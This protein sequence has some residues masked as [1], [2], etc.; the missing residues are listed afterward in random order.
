MRDGR[1][2][3]VVTG[4]TSGVG[5]AV[6]E[7]FARDGAAI[8]LLARGEDGL[9][10]TEREVARLGGIGL[11]V[12]A[13]V[14]EPPQVD[15]AASLVERNFGPIDIWIN[16]AM[17]SVFAEVKDVDAD[18]FKRVTEVTYLGLVNGTLSALQRMLP[19]DHGVIVQVGSALAYRSIPLQAAYCAAKHAGQGFTQSLRVE[20]MHD[21]SNVRTTIVHLPAL[22]TPQFDHCEAR[23]PKKPQPVPPIYQPEVAA[24]TIHWAAHHRR[25]EVWVGGTT[26]ATILAN[27]VVPGLLDRYLA[28]TGFQ[29]QQSKEDQ[30]LGA[31]SNLWKPVPGDPGAH[32]R[33]DAGARARSFQAWA[34]RHRRMLGVGGL[35]LG[36]AGG[37]AFVARL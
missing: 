35:A 10:G 5:R 15:E 21:G 6:V 31:P 17:T 32:G 28:R 9:E 29:S 1:E 24:E 37:A 33:F 3:V 26:V 7:R 12:P 4:A 18:E 14:A 36:A 11:A 8:G 20:L 27:R 13:D 30:S 34:T 25:R 23:L 22:N 2:V 19:R 16:N